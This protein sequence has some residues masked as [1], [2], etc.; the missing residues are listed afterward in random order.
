MVRPEDLLV[1]TLGERGIPSTLGLSN[2][3]GDGIADYTSD[4]AR[5]L[6]D[7]Q[8]SAGAGLEASPRMFER[9]GPREKI[10]FDP[11]RCRAAIVVCGGLCPGLNNVVRSL[12]LELFHKYGVKSAIGYRFGFAGMCG[13]DAEPPMRLTPETVRHIHR[14]GGCILG[15][16]RGGRTEREL[17]DA[18]ER[19]GVDV[20]FCVG[21]DGTLRGAHALAQELARRN[22]PIAVVGIP[23]TVD[24][25]IAF[26]ERSFGYESAVEV[27]RAAIDAAHTEATGTQNGVGVVKLMGRD[28]GFIA[29]AGTLASRE[30]NYCLVPEVPFDL[31]GPHGLLTA[32]QARLRDRGH[33]VIVVAEGCGASLPGAAAA[34]DASGNARYADADADIGPRLR[35]AIAAYLRA[36]KLPSSVK[37][38]DP[39]YT[40]R[41]IPACAS[42]SVYCWNMARH[43][44]H[45][46]MAGNTNMLIGRWHG[47][48]VHVPMALATRES[49]RVN[50]EGDLWMSVIENTGQPRTFG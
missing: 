33:A 12:V 19:D 14:Q 23:K 48:F 21:G 6:F 11:A 16:S 24:N 5:V 35:D 31:E 43:A 44:V 18:L 10:F 36:A 42:D 41:S 38:I 29:A 9:A 49:R 45:A 25:D 32:I 39:S 15:L 28:A 46:A 13:Q 7:V 4:D 17:A 40:I 20:L 47:R 27:A 3:R 2:V 30:V 8:A 22:K 26:V 34:K 1:A 50:P 37:Y